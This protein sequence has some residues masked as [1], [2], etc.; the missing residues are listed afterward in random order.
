MIYAVYVVTPK[1][2]GTEP[3]RALLTMND[4]RGRG[5]NVIDELSI[6]ENYTI[7]DWKHMLKTYKVLLNTTLLTRKNSLDALSR[8]FDERPYTNPAVF[9]ALVGIVLEFFLVL[10]YSSLNIMEPTAAL[11]D[12][13]E[14]LTEGR[15]HLRLLGWVLCGRGR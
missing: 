11:G 3:H 15:G 2:V 8:L 7:A 4:T 9:Q 14:G 1:H 6:L 10:G 13:G 5:G 12:G